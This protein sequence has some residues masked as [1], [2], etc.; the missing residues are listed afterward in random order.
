MI[1]TEPQRGRTKLAIFVAA[2]FIAFV[3][4]AM[5]QGER[6][7]ERAASLAPTANAYVSLQPA[8]AALPHLEPLSDEPLRRSAIAEVSKVEPDAAPQTRESKPP[9]ADPASF[10][11]KG[12]IEVNVALGVVG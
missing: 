4:V 1:S 12:S 2:C 8:D 6:R 3:L 10:V 9:A 7:D 5:F 11:S